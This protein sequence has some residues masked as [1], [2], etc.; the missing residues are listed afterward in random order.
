M[1]KEELKKE[2]DEL[3]DIDKQHPKMVEVGRYVSDSYKFDWFW[4]K[5]EEFKKL[6][7]FIAGA[8]SDVAKEYW[9]EVFKQKA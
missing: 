4:S 8:K 6:D 7:A 9:F 1:N 5:L 2:F 3:C